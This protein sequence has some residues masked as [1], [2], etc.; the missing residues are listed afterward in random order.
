ME[1][2]IILLARFCWIIGLVACSST[3]AGSDGGAGKPSFAPVQNDRFAITTAELGAITM[4]NQKYVR[5]GFG[6]KLKQS[7]QL[8]SVRVEDVTDAAPVL[9]INDQAPQPE[10]NLWS[11]FSGAIEP[12]GSAL[13]WLFENTPSKR[14]FRF[15][16]TDL[17]GQVSVL[18]QTVTYS[19]KSKQ[20]LT[21][22][23]ELT[24]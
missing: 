19:V 5:W 14:T 6:L 16:V 11:G 21:K 3:P 4:D 18:D 23:Y 10:G 12:N 24:A 13:P 17:N 8:R 2:R 22:G 15:T 9:L 1:N 20:A 7:V